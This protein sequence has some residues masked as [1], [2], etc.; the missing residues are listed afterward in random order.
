MD[1]SQDRVTREVLSAQ[2][3][4]GHEE[5][6]VPRI[7]SIA[8]TN[9]DQGNLRKKTSNLGAYSFSVAVSTAAGRQQAGRH[10]TRAAAESPSDPQE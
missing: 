4:Q 2:Y 5:I 8:M 1:N 10:G 3:R 6:S 9:Q 7:C